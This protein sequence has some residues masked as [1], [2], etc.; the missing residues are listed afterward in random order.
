VVLLQPH[1]DYWVQYL[2]CARN[3]NT[4]VRCNV[5][6]FPLVAENNRQNWKRIRGIEEIPEGVEAAGTDG[7]SG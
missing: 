5:E 4:E 7:Q 1:C 2:E 6:K 3:Y